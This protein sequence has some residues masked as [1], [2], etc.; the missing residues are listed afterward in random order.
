MVLQQ[1]MSYSYDGSLI[2]LIAFPCSTQQAYI[3]ASTLTMPT[4]GKRAPR[5]VQAKG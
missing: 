1:Q 5:R 3:P 2:A 4:R